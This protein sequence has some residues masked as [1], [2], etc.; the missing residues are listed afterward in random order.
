[1]PRAPSQRQKCTDVGAPDRPIVSHEASWQDLL[2]AVTEGSLGNPPRG[3]EGL[4]V[5]ELIRG[6]SDVEVRTLVAE[7]HASRFV[8]TLQDVS[9]VHLTVEEQAVSR[10]GGQ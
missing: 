3:L 8:Q 2:G 5:A 6:M 10:G 4:G 9:L 7:V 1:M